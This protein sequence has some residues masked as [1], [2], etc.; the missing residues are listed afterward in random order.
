[1]TASRP[2]T[3][4][5]AAWPGWTGSTRSARRRRPWSGVGRR[6]SNRCVRR[7]PA[8]AATARPRRRPPSP[9]P[10]ARRRRAAPRAR[11]GRAG[12]EILK[13][14]LARA[15]ALLRSALERRPPAPERDRFLREFL[16]DGAAAGK[17]LDAYREAPDAD[18]AFPILADV[19]LGSVFDRAVRVENFDD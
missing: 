14:Q 13:G 16:Y 1:P 17:A 19:L 15:G 10:R 4:C 9:P 5:S 6:T 2:A 8:W 11:S 18:A 7:S 3:A 12:A